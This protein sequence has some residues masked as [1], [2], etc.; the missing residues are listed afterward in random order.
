[1]CF[2]A[3]TALACVFVVVSYKCSH[4]LVLLVMNAVICLFC[5]AF[6]TSGLRVF[7]YQLKKDE[8]VIGML[9]FSFPPHN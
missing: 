4:L 1:M 7:S 6:A 5:F 3:I 9:P 2:L 8:T